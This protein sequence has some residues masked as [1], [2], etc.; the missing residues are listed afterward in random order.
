[1]AGAHDTEKKAFTVLLFAYITALEKGG[2]RAASY[3]TER[4]GSKNV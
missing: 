2:R 1:M 3:T 4:P